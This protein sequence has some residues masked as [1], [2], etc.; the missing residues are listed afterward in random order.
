MESRQQCETAAAGWI[1]KRDT[2]PWTEADAS[3]LEQWLSA[4]AGNRVAYYR[5]NAAWQEAGK[6]QALGVAS[7][8]VL[9][10]GPAPLEPPKRF[11]MTQRRGLQFA[12][13]LLLIVGSSS[14]LLH[15]G[16]LSGGDLHA[17]AIGGLETV[18]LQDG[19]RVILNTNSQLSIELTDTQRQVSLTHGEAF[20]EVAKDPSRPFIVT[21]GDKRIIAV[22]T[23]FS[24]R[25]EGGSL[26]VIVSEGTVRMETTSK[27][28]RSPGPLTA[29]TILRAQDDNVLVQ[30]KAPG[31]IEQSLS[32]RSGVLTFRDTPLSVAVGEF[33]RY[34][35]R[36]IVIEDPVIADMRIGGN[37]RATQP[38]PFVHLLVEGLSIHATT[39]ANRIVLRMN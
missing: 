15:H 16:A 34:N 37:F 4:S 11:V 22:G 36:Q 6:L 1:A 32:W 24:V 12:A 23:A 27:H 39:E 29:G 33:N 26:R 2:G 14:M 31:E 21:A 5:L 38:D 35:A 30:A 20:F 3:E 7:S 9:G 13:T 18:P 28:G 19:S 17:T 25:R 8:D 10:D